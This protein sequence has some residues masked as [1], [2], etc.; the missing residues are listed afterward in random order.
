M[1]PVAMRLTKAALR[2]GP[3]SYVE[4]IEWEALAQP[5]TMAT[6]DMREGLAAQGE[7]RKPTFEGR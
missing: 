1:A 3:R 5:I 7:R 2:H 6:A 4:A